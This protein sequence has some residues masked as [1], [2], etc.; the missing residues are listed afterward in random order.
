MQFGVQM[1]FGF[2][3][4]DTLAM[5]HAA[6]HVLQD[7]PRRAD[8]Q[9]QNP[10]PEARRVACLLPAAWIGNWGI[11]LKPHYWESDLGYV[12]STVY[13]YI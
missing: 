11:A 8:L 3:G 9:I 6:L 7:L 4:P 13:I 5:Q 10:K 12:L 1:R 2:R